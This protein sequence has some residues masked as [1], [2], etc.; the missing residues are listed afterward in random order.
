MR[1]KLSFIIHPHDA[2][3][4]G[5]GFC[6]CERSE[7]MSQAEYDC[8]VCA[9]ASD[10]RACG[11]VPTEAGRAGGSARGGR[12]RGRALPRFPTEENLTNV[13]RQNSMVGLVALGMTFVILTGGID[14]SVGSLVCRRRRSG[15]ELRGTWTLRRA[16]RRR[17]VRRRARAHQR[18]R[19]REGAHTAVHR[20]AGD[21]DSGARA[22]ARLHGREISER[23]A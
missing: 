7:Q 20:D 13:L 11:V 6:Y 4:H 14:L 23:A 22:R 18:P 12:L 19:Y 21:D 15:G 1:V 8:G 16:R 5:T 3:P 10:A 9:R 2:L 17:R